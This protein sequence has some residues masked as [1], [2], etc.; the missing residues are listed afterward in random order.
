MKIHEIDVTQNIIK[1]WKTVKMMKNKYDK[2][3]D[4][5]ILKNISKNEMSKKEPKTQK[6][7]K[8]QY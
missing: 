6:K 3:R 8:Y 7:K 1:K 4:K 2:K 5:F